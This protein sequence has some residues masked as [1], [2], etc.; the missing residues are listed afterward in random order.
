MSSEV[1]VFLKQLREYKTDK[2][3]V[4][5]KICVQMKISRV[6]QLFL[7][8]NIMFCVVCEVETWQYR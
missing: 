1:F 7:F 6:Q 2:N 3:N 4:Q 5:G 8:M